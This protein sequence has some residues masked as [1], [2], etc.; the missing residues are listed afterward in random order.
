MSTAT[1]ATL[2]TQLSSLRPARHH[3][4]RGRRH[5][6]RPSPRSKA[7]AA[8]RVAASSREVAIER[9]TC[10]C[11]RSRAQKAQLCKSPN[12][13]SLS[14]TSEQ[15]FR[16]KLSQST[17]PLHTLAHSAQCAQWRAAQVTATCVESIAHGTRPC[18]YEPKYR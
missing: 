9:D 15:R 14:T 3:C 12:Y 16:D 5:C 1:P 7:Q 4:R 2:A 10:S 6:Q 18:S 13:K 17:S 8:Y 11:G